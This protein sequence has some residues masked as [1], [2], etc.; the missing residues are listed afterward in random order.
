MNVKG[1]AHRARVDLVIQMY[2][3]AHW[4]RFIDRYSKQVPFWNQQI[5]PLTLIP[6]ETFLAFQ[7]ELVALFFGGEPQTYWD[8]GARSA[9]LSMNEE[10]FKTFIETR[11]VATFVSSALGSLW[12]AYYTAGKLQGEMKGSLVH[13]RLT[14]V[15]TP[16]VHFEYSVMGYIKKALELIGGS[17][18]EEERI[19]GFD[20]EDKEVYYQFHRR[21]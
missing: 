6:V 14:G 16:H 11:D 4:R 21:P 12:D 19:K 18:V 13:V 20:S 15:S 2:G 10:P 7:D 1:I 3:E 17:E 9:E 5:L 8:F